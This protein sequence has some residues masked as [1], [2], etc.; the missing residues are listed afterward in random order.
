MARSSGESGSSTTLREGKV[1]SA[2]WRG[3]T[4]SCGRPSTA[5]DWTEP[6]TGVDLGDA[7]V[8]RRNVA[9]AMHALRF[10]GVPSAA[11]TKVASTRAANVTSQRNSA[12]AKS[13]PKVGTVRKVEEGYGG[14]YIRAAVTL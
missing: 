5:R 12:Q 3:V 11:A 4:V 8:T 9:A 14:G 13:C 6:R 10:Q 7:Q 1:E 2:C